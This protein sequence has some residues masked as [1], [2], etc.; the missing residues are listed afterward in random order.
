MPWGLGKD[1]ALAENVHHCKVRPARDE[2]ADDQGSICT[3]RSTA[4]HQ[5]G[6]EARG[7]LSLQP[8]TRS[9]ITGIMA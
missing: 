6:G 2:G 4:G 7:H 8:P 5:C 3:L 1:H 9:Q